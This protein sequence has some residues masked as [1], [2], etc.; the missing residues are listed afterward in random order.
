ME[1]YSA[2]LHLGSKNIIEYCGRPFK[3]AQHQIKRLIGE[4]NNRC[5]PGDTL[6]HN[7]DFVL[8]G[9]ERGVES[10][11][12]K[13]IEFENMINCKVVHILGNHDRNNGIKGGLDFGIVKLSKNCLAAIQH[14][15]PW[16]PQAIKVDV[17]VDV[18]LCGHVHDSWKVRTFNKKPVINVGCDV[19]NYRPVSKVDLVKFI[20]KGLL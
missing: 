3:S 14:Y 10:I 5:R 7:G 12:I 18:Y 1:Y 8:Y 15:P 17:N 4:I 13:P 20:D 19:W 2:D 6:Y 9:K 11:R 16:A